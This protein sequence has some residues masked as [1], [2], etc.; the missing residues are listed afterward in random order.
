MRK[1]TEKSFI[2]TSQSAL[3]VKREGK[4]GKCVFFLQRSDAY[5][6]LA[7][8]VCSAIYSMLLMSFHNLHFS[9]IKGGAAAFFCVC[10]GGGFEGKVIASVQRSC[11]IYFLWVDGWRK[12]AHL[13][14]LTCLHKSCQAKEKR[15]KKGGNVSCLL[16]FPAESKK[17][18][19]E[20]AGKDTVTYQGRIWLG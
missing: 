8:E 16:S 2:L 14:L 4:W 3:T 13:L 15:K 9:Q 18:G 20:K 6:K 17:E 19:K 10:W 11:C 1:I 12:M 7:A 5:C